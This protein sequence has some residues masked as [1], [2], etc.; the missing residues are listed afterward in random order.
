MAS[1]VLSLD[2]A[3]LFLQSLRWTLARAATAAAAANAAARSR[4]VLGSAPPGPSAL[5]EDDDAV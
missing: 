4:S 1:V 2:V 3:V 5:A